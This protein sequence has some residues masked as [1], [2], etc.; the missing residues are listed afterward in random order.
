MQYPIISEDALKV[1]KFI[2]KYKN[3]NKSVPYL[4]MEKR[5]GEDMLNRCLPEL[6]D[7]GFI[8]WG[9]SKSAETILDERNDNVL[10]EQ[11]EGRAEHDAKRHARKR[12]KDADKPIMPS[13]LRTFFNPFFLVGCVLGT[14]LAHFVLNQ[15]LFR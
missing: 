13:I 4:K 7:H 9:V 5:F 2:G 14:L 8:G 12:R 11:S 6:I 1:L 15:L 3:K 10:D